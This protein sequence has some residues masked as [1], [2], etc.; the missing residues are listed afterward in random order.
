MA[1]FLTRLVAEKI[2]DTASEYRGLW[3]LV[4]PLVYK[5]DLLA[6][7]VIVPRGFVTDLE[8]CPRLPVVFAAFGAMADRAAVVHD[9]LYTRPDLCARA[10]ADAVLKEACR[11][12]GL[13][14]WRAFGIWLGVRIGGGGHYGQAA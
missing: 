10:T 4:E 14:G 12:S 9:Y 6:E 7:A 2:D 8:S 11:V 1:D 3:K 5:S 13:P